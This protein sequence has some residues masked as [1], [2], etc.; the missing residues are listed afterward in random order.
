MEK[1]QLLKGGIVL[2][3]DKAGRS[4][5][6]DITIK[7]GKISSI[8]YEGKTS[9]T[10]F[11]TENPGG[12]VIDAAGMII[13]PGFFNSRLVS[14]Y[15]LC[16]MFF[17]KCS[18]DN[19]GS[20]VSLNLIDRYLA[21]KVNS[22]RLSDILE[23]V[24]KRSL[25][26]GEIF[27]N[28]SSPAFKKFQINDAFSD[29]KSVEQYFNI[30]AYDLKLMEETGPLKSF[31]SAGFRADEDINSYAISSL[32]RSLQSGHGRLMIDA[33]LSQAAY[34]SVRQ[35]FGKPYIN[36]L[37]EN[38]LLS[39][40]TL[41]IN[42]LNVTDGEL[43]IIK[44]KNASILFCPSD[45]A[46]MSGDLS[47]AGRIFDSGI[48]ILLG[49][50]LTGTDILSEL[51]IIS[52]LG[53]T[54]ALPYESLLRSAT[55]GPAGFFGISNVTGA[56]EKTKSADMILFSLRDIRNSGGMPD[57]DSETICWHLVN[58][59]TAK[60]ISGIIL[61]GKEIYNR[62]IDGN[63]QES[64]KSAA[65]IAELSSLLYSAGKLREYKE[66]KQMN[67]RVE[68]LSL[69]NEYEEETQARVFVDMTETGEYLGEGEFKILGN[70]IEE[71]RNSRE[72]VQEDHPGD[73][74][75][76]KSF[77]E[78]LN[79]IGDD[80]EIFELPKLGIRLV[81]TKREEKTKLA[82]EQAHKDEVTGEEIEDEFSV[83]PKIVEHKVTTLKRSSL[84]FGFKEGE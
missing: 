78:D 11:L 16:R 26:N 45:F 23:L 53:Y 10:Q 42:P 79:L 17:R 1:P 25:M 65:K 54:R 62:A 33:S 7:N 31:I 40:N 84:K 69:G 19:N 22:G 74:V 76:I 63:E 70:K 21:E 34:E 8:D 4:G 44:E 35:T 71:F 64:L 51:K 66:R 15:S 37:A 5:I 82:D 6:F 41:L 60:D 83:V 67:K 13:L 43:G 3:L 39:S 20:S 55:T 27:V 12:K 47:L 28:E 57:L 77:E 48:N 18:Y 50:G 75:E 52:A 36:V 14:A 38:G 32:K 81:E 68:D 30:T 73:L 61:K 24:Y 2:S 56:I 29:L 46:N 49:T 59:L 72:S 58:S 80:E 9:T